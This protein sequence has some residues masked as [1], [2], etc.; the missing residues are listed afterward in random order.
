[1]GTITH[2]PAHH[3]TQRAMWT[4]ITDDG[5]RYAFAVTRSNEYQ[6][7]KRGWAYEM[8]YS[9][10]DGVGFVH[11]FA[12]PSELIYVPDHDAD[13][14]DVLETLSSFFDAWCEARSYST[15]EDSENWSLFPDRME[16]MVAVSDLFSLDMNDY[17]EGRDQ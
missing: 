7:G 9:P 14:R 4:H 2:T 6:F 15:A 17:V 10:A 12:R 16:A 11:T 5:T 3:V 1:M 13:P 8:H